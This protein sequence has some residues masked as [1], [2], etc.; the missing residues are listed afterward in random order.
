MLLNILEY[1]C[2]HNIAPNVLNYKNLTNNEHFSVENF[3]LWLLQQDNYAII[4][5][6]A[7]SGKR[8]KYI[9]II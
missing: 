6:I 3:Y 9:M 1:C 4:A 7:M 2:Y 8:P 5:I